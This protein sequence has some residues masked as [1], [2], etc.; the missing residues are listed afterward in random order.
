MLHIM[1]FALIVGIAITLLPAPVS[2]PFVG[3]M[4]RVFA[5]HVKDHRHHYEVRA[6]CRRVSDF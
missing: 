6:V 3:V 2:A 1:F 5:D 4:D